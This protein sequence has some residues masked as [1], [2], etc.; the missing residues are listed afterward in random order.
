MT[1]DW[2]TARRAPGGHAPGRL[3]SIFMQQLAFWT[4]V[5]CLV[6]FTGVIVVRDAVFGVNGLTN[7]QLRYLA[8]PLAGLGL[9]FLIINWRR[10]GALI[11]ANG[12]LL[13][14]LVLAWL[15]S[16][17][18]VDPARTSVRTFALLLSALG[19]FGLVVHF[20]SMSLIRVVLLAISV[21]TGLSLLMYHAGDPMVFDELAMIGVRGVFTHKNMLG[22]ACVVA[23]VLSA[24]LML[25]NN[26]F[27]RALGL[28]TF[29]IALRVMVLALS[30][31]A[32]VA[33]AVGLG[34][35]GV[36]YL[37]TR[38]WVT[39]FLKP[40]IAAAAVTVG[41]IVVTFRSQII[42]LLGREENLTGR[43]DIW[44]FTIER[45]QDAP[46]FGHGYRAY[47]TAPQNVD[48]VERILEQSYDQAHNSWLQLML[49]LGVVGVIFFSVWLLF[50]FLRAPKAAFDPAQQIWLALICAL[51]FNSYTE[52]LILAPTSF[53]W[54]IFQIAAIAIAAVVNPQPH[55]VLRRPQFQMQWPAPAFRL[56]R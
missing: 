49:D 35:L 44:N 32:Y 9:L 47:F 38:P 14:I 8:L 4:A 7:E 15:S 1:P 6:I 10:S 23:I 46:I 18:S 42:A 16:L 24:G 34:V 41:F 40:V 31:T 37:M 19:A 55:A 33:S 3:R 28:V 36:L 26:L 30:A 17:W 25:R 39:G 43:D 45:I 52:A 48:E 12:A 21:G 53:T 13:A 2:I 51:L 5:V 20:S 22:Q 11:W 54:L 29:L 27:D 56:R 50:I